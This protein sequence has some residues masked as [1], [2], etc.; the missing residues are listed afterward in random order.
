VTPL[1]VSMENQAVW[2]QSGTANN[3]PELGKKLSGDAAVLRTR[4]DTVALACRRIRQRGSFY[5][6]LAFDG[7][8]AITGLG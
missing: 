3:S 6:H 5:C 4:T 2:E 1:S 7:V 8:A